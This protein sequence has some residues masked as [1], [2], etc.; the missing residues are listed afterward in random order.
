MILLAL[1]AVALVARVAV[2]A[3]FMDPAYPDSYYYVNVARQVAAGNGFVVD[4]IW[5]FVD[6]G[7]RLPDQAS[8]PI[9][10]NGHWMPLA[11]LVQ[12][13]F[14]WLLGPT[15]LASALPFWL[16]GAVA[17]PLTYL[18]GLDAG[19]GRGVAVTAG[20][21]TAVPA[22]V[23]PFMAQPDNFGLFMPLGA[24]ALWLATRA[25][26]GQGW[27]WLA[28]GAVVGLATLA[29]NDGVLLGL[30]F[31]LAGL[32][33]LLREGQRRAALATGAACVLAFVAAT[34]PWFARQLE[35]FGTLSPSAASGRIL[36]IS[37][38]RQ[39]W[40][41]GDL[42]TLESLLATGLGPLLASRVEG[43][44]WAVGIFA[45]LPLAVVM[46]PFAVIGGWSLR[47]DRAFWPFYIYGATLFGASG[48]LFAVH[49][50]EGT[51]LH[52]AVAL[53]PHT[54][55]LV[56]V[57]V[58]R[59]VEWVAERRPSW[60]PQTAGPFFRAG[61]VAVAV[62]AALVQSVATVAAWRANDAPR[63]AL[64]PAMATI[65][66][67]ELVMSA[68]PGAYRYLFGR[69]G[70]V[71]PDDPLALI[72]TAARAYGVRW[73]VLERGQIVPALEPVLRGELQ[74]AWLSP[75]IALVG[76]APTAGISSTAAAGIETA[77][78]VAPTTP[79]A[80]LYAVCFAE[81]DQRC[82]P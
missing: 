41:A 56:A 23:L 66:A 57:G 62:L 3:F 1:F 25:L 77:A 8:L 28:G 20:L 70:I 64:G 33:G 6:V 51:F 14:I 15:A 52:S 81:L 27:A 60:Q 18:I 9:P 63:A 24:L 58:G 79:R 17:A 16:A 44:L 76:V 4:Y 74:P 50:A 40:S 65:P 53:L 42:P 69:G 31:A 13:P 5:N 54:F 12:V 34:G 48:L 26:R 7:G 21:L 67:D 22:A 37:D 73:L 19:L 80:A 32:G 59:A 39:L 49:V 10:A 38:Y 61:L 11:V 71:T 29:R 68:D 2:G 36:L 82:T 43:L 75:P 78:A 45:V 35:V 55:L 46:A 47:S 30:P 72:E